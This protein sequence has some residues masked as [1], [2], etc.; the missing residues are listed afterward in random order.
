MTES[1]DARPLAPLREAATAL[2]NTQGEGW[3]GLERCSDALDHL[4]YSEGGDGVGRLEVVEPSPTRLTL[5]GR[6]T[7]FYPV[8]AAIWWR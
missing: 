5:V 3:Q 8:T 7:G 1:S 4:L 2:H 6:C